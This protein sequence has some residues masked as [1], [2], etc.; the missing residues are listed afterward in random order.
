MFGGVL[1]LC[2]CPKT[3]FVLISHDSTA[4]GDSRRRRKLQS[5]SLDP[6][7]HMRPCKL[8]TWL[9]LASERNPTRYGGASLVSSFLPCS[10][11]RGRGCSSAIPTSASAHLPVPSAALIHLPLEAAAAGHVF[12]SWGRLYK[13]ALFLKG[14]WWA[15]AR[16]LGNTSHM[17]TPVPHL[18]V[19]VPLCF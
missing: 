12:D 10:P 4:R 8:S 18:A 6:L 16:L 1:D 5:P 9:I 2:T 15:R 11:E 19:P 7:L 17:Q 14:C 13:L 3:G